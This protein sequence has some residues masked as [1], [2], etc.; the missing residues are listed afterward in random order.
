MQKACSTTYFTSKHQSAIRPLC[1]LATK[2]AAA[3]IV[4]LNTEGG[5]SLSL[6]KSGEVKGEL[7][8]SKD[9]EEARE[10]EFFDSRWKE[11][12][13]DLNM[14]IKNGKMDWDGVIVAGNI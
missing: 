9:R 10:P 13:W 3:P 8:I 14:F 2:P 7:T 5:K 12:T 6:D 11:G 1:S 4:T